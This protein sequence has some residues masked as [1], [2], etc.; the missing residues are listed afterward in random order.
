MTAGVIRRILLIYSAYIVY[1]RSKEG[2]G[3]GKKD[4]AV[5]NAPDGERPAPL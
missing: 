4:G 1:K 2:C 5:Y 3:R